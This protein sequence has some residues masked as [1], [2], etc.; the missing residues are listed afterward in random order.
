MNHLPLSL[1]SSEVLAAVYLANNL[2][3]RLSQH[4]MALTTSRRHTKAPRKMEIKI[5]KING[6]KIGELISLAVLVL[7]PGG[8]SG[9]L[10]DQGACPGE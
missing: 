8:N 10:D 3:G 4:S 9:E 6:M 1:S 2:I 7:W 5:T